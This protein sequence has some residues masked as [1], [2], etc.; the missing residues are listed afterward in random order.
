[1]KKVNGV[2]FAVVSLLVLS[3]NET[4]RT[5]LLDGSETEPA[6]LTYGVGYID[7]QT[8][9]MMDETI[10]RETLWSC[11]S[12]YC[13]IM[14]NNPR[15]G[16][17]PGEFKQEYYDFR[18][19]LCTADL[20]MEIARSDNG[21]LISDSPESLKDVPNSGFSYNFNLPIQ[22]GGDS[23]AF[24]SA[25]EI[26]IEPLTNLTQ[27]ADVREMA[28]RTYYAALANALVFADSSGGYDNLADLIAYSKDN[29]F[30]W[31][32]PERS[33]GEMLAKQMFA[34]IPTVINTMREVKME[35]AD[36]MVEEGKA[37]GDEW[38]RND[39]G[40]MP[41]LIEIAGSPTCSSDEVLDSTNGWCWKRC[42]IGQS[43]NSARCVGTAESK[44]WVDAAAACESAGAELPSAWQ[45]RS[46][47][48]GCSTTTPPLYQCNSCSA[49]PTCDTWFPGESRVFWTAT[50]YPD[51]SLIIV[52][53]YSDGDETYAATTSSYYTRC[54]RRLGAP[55]VALMPN[56]N[57]AL[58]PMSN[59]LRIAASILKEAQINVPCFARYES[60][61]PYASCDP[62]TM[63]S[64]IL[65]SVNAQREK[66]DQVP[67]GTLSEYAEGRGTTPQHIG[68]AVQYLYTQLLRFPRATSVVGD[69]NSPTALFT[70]WE[71]PTLDMPVGFYA[72]KYSIA[73]MYDSGIPELTLDSGLNDVGLVPVFR[74]IQHQL[75]VA[76]HDP[77]GL[78]VSTGAVGNLSDALLEVH[79]V[80][81][82]RLLR[83]VI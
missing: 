33:S 69:V 21:V 83:A 47:L 31:L 63:E 57:Q 18:Q 26:T 13:N 9:E 27:R 54:I 68:N 32:E 80:L 20:L 81:G 74:W 66:F 71:E 10:G 77:T 36:E 52:M 50:K 22:C 73:Y 37:T 1:M 60:A 64:T 65:D 75:R 28:F 12:G 70:G 35:I 45:A 14:H 38:T 67:Y 23:T 42:P 11:V 53:D 51:S 76:L 82:D 3:C 56:G 16:V 4:E 8:T 48:A 19:A 79:N 24:N 55:S 58:P 49:S 62:G 29:W 59:A 25:E 39:V 15:Y 7:P 46:V 72:S 78:L 44:N 61:G 2:L 5:V 40:R 17:A 6:A 41:A 30:Y 34:Q 43:W